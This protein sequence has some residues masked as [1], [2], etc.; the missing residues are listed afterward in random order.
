M[1]KIIIKTQEEIEV[2]RQNGLIL[3]NAIALVAENL[4]PGVT[5]LYLDK[6]AE[7]FIRDN[8]A[9]PSFKGYHKFPASL[10][11]SINEDVVHGI[12]H[13]L[14]IKEGD[15][16]SIDAG[17]YKNDFHADSAYT[18][19]VGNVA[20][21][22]LQLMRVTKESLYLGIE[23]AIAGNRTGDIGD[24]IQNYCERK[25]PYKCVRELVGHGL[26]RAIHE[27][28]QVPNYG[29]SGK[30]DLLPE[31]CVIA[32]EPMVNL[33][34]KDV[35]TK[36]DNWTIATQ[37]HKPSA[38]YEHSICVQKD[39]AEILTTFEPIEAAIKKNPALTF[40]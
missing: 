32:I 4:K 17:V 39:K 31:N 24:A 13:A 5:G 16:V 36:N 34:R 37:D 23:K 35:Y 7:Q 10:C 33:G 20:E 40:V 3:A 6:L 27:E 9:T 1:G 28:P 15:I 2:I 38:H 29:R 22:V 18:L 14:A 26:G 25:N 12:P 11:I 30:G 8:G 21:A 19:A